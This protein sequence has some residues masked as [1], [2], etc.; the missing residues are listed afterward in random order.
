MN[1]PKNMMLLIILLCG[2]ALFTGCGKEKDTDIV[3]SDTLSVIRTEE[4]NGKKEKSGELTE[5]DAFEGIYPSFSGTSPDGTASIVYKNKTNPMRYFYNIEPHSDLR[6]GDV[7]KISIDDDDP[8][9]TANKY[10]Y[11]LLE[12]EKEFVVEGL[13]Y[14]VETIDEISDEMQTKMKDWVIS[15]IE[16]DMS[17][18]VSEV[19][20]NN[21][22]TMGYYL[23]SKMTNAYDLNNHCYGIYKITLTYSEQKISYYYCARF[24]NIIIKNDGSCKV[25]GGSDITLD[26]FY[27]GDYR[28]RGCQT[29]DEVYEECVEDWCWDTENYKL[30]TNITK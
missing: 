27:E 11:T 26:S 8:E 17:K 15:S 29:L 7:V 22:E 2:A 25:T 21:C 14:Y 30:E 28:V 20:L 3:K 10:G 18:R 12:T 19:S 5:F 16:A 24:D 13:D 6:N 1:T 23:L 4:D 9:K